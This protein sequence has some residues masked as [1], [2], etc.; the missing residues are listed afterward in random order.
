MKK[1]AA[2][3][4]VIL[5]GG[6]LFAGGCATQDVVKMDEP[7]T[8]V[9]VA[10]PKQANEKPAKQDDGMMSSKK[11]GPVQLT[12]QA[13]Q[14]KAETAS[15][16]DMQLHLALG[17]IYFDFDATSLS[18][19]ARSTLT[20]NAAL[21]RN[22]TADTVRIEGHCD[23][24]GSN[25]YNLALGEKRANAAMK[26]LVTMGIPEKQLSVISYG[27]EKPAEVGHNETA[28]AKNRRDDF[29]VQYGK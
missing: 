5:C 18:D 2:L 13:A 9:A 14:I 25:E 15:S 27:K 1:H 22:N 28:W 12:P 20:K 24:R 23:E 3:A 8:P 10:H 26:Y 17:K 21:M 7:I 4:F 16:K 19:Q 6:V 11:T 29:V